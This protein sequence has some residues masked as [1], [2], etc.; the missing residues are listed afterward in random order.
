MK[1]ID[2]ALTDYALTVLCFLFVFM[3]IKDYSNS[4]LRNWFAILFLSVGL[5]AV[6]GGTVHGFFHEN[7]L[8]Y[9]IF[10]DSTLL[11]IGVSALSAWMIGA[12]I[13]FGTKG[14][15]A[16]SVLAIVNF[17]FY[18]FYVL[19]FNQSFGV[20]VANYLPAAF[21]LLIA[22]FMAYKRT[23]HRLA[24]FA[25]IGLILTF[26]AAGIQQLEIG[27]HAQYFNHN[28]LYHLVQA[29]GLFLVFRGARFMVRFARLFAG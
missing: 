26:V 16:V 13:M 4:S 29:L 19:F 8:S 24:L 6:L 1:E 20:A 21:F 12:V 11:S 10:W 18:L 14:R 7:S 25:L 22:F 17:A 27:I 3:L 28:A 5:A 2:V 23:V 15:K 9:A